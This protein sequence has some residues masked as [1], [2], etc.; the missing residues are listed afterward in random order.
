VDYFVENWGNFV[1][2]LGLLASVGGL[3]YACLARRAAKSAEKAARE[4]RQALART[5]SSIDV[6]RAVAMINRL[7]EVHRQGNWDHALSMYQDLRRTLSEIG[8]SIPQDL[9][10][11]RNSVQESIPQITA[12]IN[13]VNRF[14]DG[15]DH[16]RPEYISS[17]NEILNGIQQRLEMLQGSMLHTD[18]RRGD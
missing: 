14:R 12:M 5:I 16:T 1:G 15:S 7:M 10:E 4:A 17:L 8:T 2:L 6:E 13:L 9:V 11:Y 18:D 3:F